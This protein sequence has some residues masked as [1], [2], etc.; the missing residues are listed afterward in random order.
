MLN[1]YKGW[2]IERTGNSSYLLTR[3]SP[4]EGKTITARARTQDHA[5][6]VIVNEEAKIQRERLNDLTYTFKVSFNDPRFIPSTYVLTRCKSA[7]FEYGN[8]T[9]VTVLKNGVLLGII[10]TRY[11]HSVMEDFRKWCLEY[12]TD[13]FDPAYDPKIEEV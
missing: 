1:K 8:K 13:S 12:L 10:D 4:I 11:D 9:S 3:I 5:K 2:T 6:T 7:A